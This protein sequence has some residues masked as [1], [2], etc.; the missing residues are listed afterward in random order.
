MANRDAEE[1]LE[2]ISDSEWRAVGMPK[3]A[4]SLP[5]KRVLREVFRARVTPHLAALIDAQIAQAKGIKYLVKRD[6]NGRFRR[7]GPEGLD[8]PEGV[9]EVWEKDPSTV[10]FADLMNRTLDK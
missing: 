9:Y 10:A 8:D 2:R 7:I 6:E 5:S 4:H 3:P 1:L